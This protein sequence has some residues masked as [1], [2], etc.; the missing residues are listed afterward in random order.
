MQHATRADGFSFVELLVALTIALG[1]TASALLLMNPSQ[2]LAASRSET[3]DMQ[4]R[5]RVAADT[6]Y[7]RLAAAGAGAYA[8]VDAGPLID[9]R[10]SILP[11]RAGAGSPDPP[12]SFKSDTVTIL[13]VPRNGA[14]PAG[15]TYWLKTENATATYQLMAVDTASGVDVPVVDHIVA[16]ALEYFGDAQPPIMRKPLS[17]PVGPW[18]TYGPKPA[19]AAVA[20]F[21]AGENCVFVSDGS[22]TPQP[23]LAVLGWAGESLVK[24]TPSQ[25]TDGPWCPNDGAADRWDADLLRIRSIAVQ[26]RV[27]AAVSTLRGPASAL[28]AHGGTSRGGHQ[29][30]PDQE[31]WFQVS[32]RNLNLRR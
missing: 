13:S 9:S 6:L 24:L 27:Q 18:T 14:Q 4:Q 21:A 32:P 10:A 16:L 8:G 11:Y 20:P 19:A 31:C 23:R 29:W 25:L 1:V 12:G 3:A 5:L 26:L 30:L 15:T 2:A 17:E 28:F 22:S 7:Q